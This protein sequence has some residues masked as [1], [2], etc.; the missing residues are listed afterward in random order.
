MP[1]CEICFIDDKLIICPKCSRNV[2]SLCSKLS[3]CDICILIEM[4]YAFVNI[5]NTFQLHQQHKSQTEEQ[6]YQLKQI[7]D[8]INTVNQEI[9]L[10]Q[11]AS[12]LVKKNENKKS[13]SLEFQMSETIIDKQHELEDIESEIENQKLIIRMKN[14]M[15][16]KLDLKINEA[17]KEYEVLQETLNLKKQQIYQI[18]QTL[19]NKTSL[20]R[21]S[22]D[23]KHYSQS[24]LR[25][26]L[27]TKQQKAISGEEKLQN[28]GLC[29]GQCVIQ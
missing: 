28:P 10:I 13:E 23:E 26:T 6:E 7:N 8:K 27:P 12:S 15:P 17:E 24:N 14:Q 25:M 16:Q 19:K 3:D 29:A 9:S 5:D 21:A 20:L 18:L 4:K 2:C 11:K 1:N 22:Q